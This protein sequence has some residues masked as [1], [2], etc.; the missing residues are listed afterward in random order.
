[1]TLFES[2]FKD[3]AAVRRQ[4]TAPLCRERIAFLTYMQEHDR[5]RNT[6]RAMAS[7]LL[8]I[9]R[10]LGF[11]NGMRV[12][13]MEELKNAGREWAK[14]I[15]PLRQRGP[16]KWSYELYMRIARGWLRFN[17]CLAE[18]RKTRILEEKLRDFE[19]TLQKRF[20]LAPSTIEVRAKHASWFLNWISHR[21]ISLRH[22]GVGHLERYLDAKKAEGWALS[23]LVLATY[24][25]E[26]F[27]RHA[28]GRGWVRPGLSLGAPTYAIPRHD[29][30]PKGPSWGD[31][32]KMLASMDDTEPAE[33][34]DHAMV[35]LMAVYG[36]RVGDVVALQVADIDFAQRVL[37][38]PRRKNGV[39]QRFPLNRE[40]LRTLRMYIASARPRSYCPALFTTFVA[41]YQRLKES[42]VYLR[43]RAQF[44]N[45]KIDSLR[46]GPHALRHACAKRLMKRGTSVP[47]IAAY[48][49]HADTNTVREY[50]R[51]EHKALRKIA[52]FSLEGLF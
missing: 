7:H 21:K 14:Y 16:G 26:K 39:T 42:T 51:Y 40:T 25:I 35:L 37:T 34:R 27:F 44:A 5:K 4:L 47:E 1:M 30:V 13:T 46:K 19:E 12:V 3:R 20:A 28:E 18:P 43:V 52:E 36:L 33:L 17:S 41:P 23:T 22:V 31:V 50:A 24:S 8:Q 10:T 29:F 48:L 32:Q 9:N 2:L 11:S 6:V 45:N 49:G 38:V 15:G